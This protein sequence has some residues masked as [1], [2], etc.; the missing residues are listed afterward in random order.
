MSQK[1]DNK[2]LQGE[3]QKCI[4]DSIE[5]LYILQF[6]SLVVLHDV[7]TAAYNSFTYP[8]KLNDSCK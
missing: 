7:R 6:F 1:L 2:L 4:S 5:K 8:Y 3:K